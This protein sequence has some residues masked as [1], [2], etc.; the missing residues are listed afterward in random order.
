MGFNK[1][2]MEDQRLHLAE[3]EANARHTTEKQILEDADHLLEGIR[4]L[5]TIGA[6]NGQ[7]CGREATASGGPVYS[8]QP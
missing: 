4:Y 7:G 1:R 5:I 2:K 8:T 3:K 6:K